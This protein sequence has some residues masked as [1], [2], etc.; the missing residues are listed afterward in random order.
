MNQHS[1]GRLTVSQT[2]L[3]R[4]F[5]LSLSL[6]PFAPFIFYFK[7]FQDSRLGL[8]L[9]QIFPN[10]RN[11]A[12]PSLSKSLVFQVSRSG[13][14]NSLTS[15]PEFFHLLSLLLTRNL[16]YDSNLI[17]MFDLKSVQI[18]Q[19]KHRKLGSRSWFVIMLV[20]L[21]FDRLFQSYGNET[22]YIL[23]M[24]KHFVIGVS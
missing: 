9:P 22:I 11:E 1:Q 18:N 15:P 16:F 3:N 20:L 2:I 5:I 12:S 10:F 6:P 19:S 21:I 17:E 8:S 13:L 23:N 24:W 14:F 7:F 4:P